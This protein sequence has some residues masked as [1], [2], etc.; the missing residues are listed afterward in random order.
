MASAAGPSN[1]RAPRRGPP[2]SPRPRPCA[3][4]LPDLLLWRLAPRKEA[5]VVEVKGPTDR[6][7]DQQR[8]WLA[9][10]AA[11]GMHVEVCKIVEPS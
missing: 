11:A 2:P 10:M 4:G 3:G 1:R 7:S 6:L 8:A 5:R 9:A